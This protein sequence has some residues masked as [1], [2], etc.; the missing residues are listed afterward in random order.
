MNQ[1]PTHVLNVVTGEGQASRFTEIA[2]LWPT[3]D[4]NGFTGEIPAGITITGRLVILKRK[5]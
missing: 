1:R 2:G 5:D 3:R 4:G